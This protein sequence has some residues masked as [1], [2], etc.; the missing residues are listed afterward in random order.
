MIYYLGKKFKIIRM[1]YYRFTHKSLWG[2]NGTIIAI[3]RDGAAMKRP[4]N[5][6]TKLKKKQRYKKSVKCYY[7]GEYYQSDYNHYLKMIS[8]PVNALDKSFF[9]Y[10]LPMGVND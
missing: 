1:I 7:P 8:K 3:F 4:K 6:L 2:I 5:Y 10:G 9:D